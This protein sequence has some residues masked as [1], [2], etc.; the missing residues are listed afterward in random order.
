MLDTMAWVE[1]FG[2][3]LS[4]AG[5][6]D[7]GLIWSEVEGWS[8]L[9]DGRGAGDLK[10]GTHGSFGRRRV[11]RESRPITLKGAIYADDNAGLV[12]ARERLE[13]ALMEGV[14]TMTVSTPATGSWSREVEIDTLD[15]DDDHGRNFTFFTID[16]IAPDP[17]RYGPLQLV[18]P[19]SLPRSEGGVR[20]P[21]RFPWN[22]GSTT[23]GGRLLVENSGLVPMSPTFLVTGGF[24]RVT[25]RDITSGDRMRL[26]RAVH[27]GEVLRLDAASRRATIGGS[28]VTRWMSARQWPVIKRGDVHEYRFEVDGRIGDPTL[29]A[30]FKIGAP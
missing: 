18:G 9:T 7:S 19:V 11:L 3:T 24:S 30:E 8:G 10:P 25:V 14:G 22:F 13:A 6:P 12:A 4:G 28:E 26:D 16:M 2:V 1:L 20:L 29:T 5:R 27:E 17:R 21:Q 15:I 23:E